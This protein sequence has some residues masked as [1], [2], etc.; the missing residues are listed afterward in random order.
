M[1]EIPLTRGQVALIDDAD[2]VAIDWYFWYALP[3]R[4][5]GFYAVRGVAG[6]LV[7]MHR[8]I[9]GLPRSRTPEIDHRDGNGLH[10]CRSN[11]RIAT[12]TQNR[13]NS[14]K[15]RVGRS[16]FKGVAWCPTGRWRAQIRA[17]GKQQH[18]GRFTTEEDAAR[19]YDVAARQY[20][21]EF[22]STNFP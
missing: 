17:N 6:R 8:E 11:L 13:V 2:A 7:Y 15:A 12:A 22:A 21:G 14:R 10:N 3:A 19:A 18:L 20:Y 1:V 5:A 4:R 9:M 16:R